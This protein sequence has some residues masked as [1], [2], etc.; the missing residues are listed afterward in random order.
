MRR[1]TWICTANRTNVSVLLGNGD[2]TSSRPS[3]MARI[4]AGAQWTI[5]TFNG[6]GSWTWHWPRNEQHQ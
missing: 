6:D 2:G 5:A 1:E 4:P 3:A